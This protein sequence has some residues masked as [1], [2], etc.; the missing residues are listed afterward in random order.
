MLGRRGV[1]GGLLAGLAMPLWAETPARVP[2]P[3]RR[4][5][6]GEDRTSRQLVEGAKLTGALAYIVADRATG[7]VLASKDD[8][9]PLPPASVAKAV[10]A[11]YA[12]DALGPDHRFVTRVM[13]VGEVIGGRLEGDLYLVGGGDPTLDTDSLGDLVAALAATGLKEITGRFIACDGALPQRFQIAADQPAFLGYNPAIS[14]L[15]LNFN[16][17]NL[18]WA[19][20]GDD[21]RLSF[22]ARGERFVPLVRIATAELVARE[23]PRF[24]Y[25]SGE[26]QDHWTV[27]RSALVE[28]GS[29][30]L[31]VRHPGLYAAEVFATLAEAHGLRL[32]AAE[33]QPR[34]PA[35]A[36]AVVAHESPVLTEVLRSML[37]YS[38]NLTAEAVGLT[39]SAAGSLEGSAAAMTDWARRHFGLMAEFHDHSGLGSSSRITAAELAQVMRRAPEVRN[40]ALL[41]GILRNMGLTD[42]EGNEVKGSPIRIAAKSGTLNFVSNLAGYIT[43]GQRD[44]VFAIIAADPERRAAVPM[45]ARE[46]PE[47]GRGWTRRARRLQQG[48]IRRWVELYA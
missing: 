45:E 27:A 43:G 24:T 21:W 6:P 39:A 20:A 19:R 46:E 40:G 13:R 11:L 42:S 22:D 16:R 5:A 38:T 3:P 36:V 12:L 33:L 34:P 28:D 32:P 15:N 31:P 44:L 41:P 18:A 48:L 14:G 47:G 35:E 4:P 29:R 23:R 8:D 26:R 37:R 9:V 7:R 10:T 30:W 25:E 2:R 17:V 1:L